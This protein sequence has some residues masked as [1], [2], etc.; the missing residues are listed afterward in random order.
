VQT[1]DRL[2][3]FKENVD[4]KG[5]AEIL[6]IKI[7]QTQ[8]YLQTEDLSLKNTVTLLKSLKIVLAGK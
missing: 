1:L 6:P 4:T 8:N 3:D 7:N 2:C 5:T